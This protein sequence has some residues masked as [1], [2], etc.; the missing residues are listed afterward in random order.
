MRASGHEVVVVGGGPAGSTAA[1]L[2]ARDGRRVL[3][4]DRAEFPRFS[5]GE[6]L[7]PA[8]Y[9]TL[10]R[11]GVLDKLKTSPY[12]R[13][14]SVQFFAKDGRSS[15]PFYFSEIDPHESSVTWQVDRWSFDRLLL[16]NAREAGVEVRE[17]AN[18]KDVLFEGS[19]A[20]GV[21]V[22]Y[23]DGG[24]EEISARVVVDASGQTAM[25]ARKLKLKNMDPKLRHAA[26]FT[27]YRGAV[28]DEGIDEGAT[29][30]LQTDEDRSWFWYIPL[31]DDLVSVGVV[32]P[33]DYLI[34]GRK[35]DPRIVF[36]EELERCPTLQARIDGA[37][38]VT[39]VRVMRD[40]SYIS[41]RIAGNGWV[42]AGDAFGFLDPIYSSGVFLALKSAEFA[43]DSVIE[44]FEK[45]DF[46]AARLGR[47]GPQYV[48]AMESLRKLVYAYY[49]ESFSIARFLKRNPQFRSQVVNL[50]I[51][52]VFRV[53]PDG[54][55]EAMEKEC[56]L[57]AP[58]H[59]MPPGEPS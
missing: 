27:R 45:G 26:V 41:K 36:R 15:V 1:T 9:W 2:I 11:L 54:L 49:D 13:K 10:E 6:S 56:D 47:H 16:D 38:Q 53:P 25:M 3:L 29:S 22:E 57:P 24:R 40:F 37:E 34:A 30:I 18:V 28:R 21:L 20:A 19:R 5:V 14:H 23:A 8:S 12:P 42:M 46:S 51:G 33:I 32:G 39:E 50:L 17:R 44:A 52:N 58:R 7:M 55:F 31:P 48:E 43:A 59:L 4:L 35:S